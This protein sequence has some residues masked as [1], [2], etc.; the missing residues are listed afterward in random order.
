M[1]EWQMDLILKEGKH[2]QQY[3]HYKYDYLLMI[4]NINY[5]DLILKLKQ[6]LH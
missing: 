1:F 6:I 2:L 5:L 4:Y 3:Y